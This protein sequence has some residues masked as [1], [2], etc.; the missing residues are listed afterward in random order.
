MA[1]AG[2]HG[3]RTLVLTDTELIAMQPLNP[4]KSTLK[5]L[6]LRSNHISFVPGGYFLGFKQIKKLHFTKNA[7]RLVPDIVTLH[8][9]IV[10]LCFSMHDIHSIHGWLNEAI[11][12]QLTELHLND[13][14]I[15]EFNPNMLSYCPRLKRLNLDRNRLVHLP[16]AYPEDRYKNCSVCAVTFSE[17]P[18]HC[19]RA[20]EGII[21][22]R[23]KESFSARIN[24]NI[25]TPELSRITCSCPLHLRGRDLQTMGMWTTNS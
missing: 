22:L 23:H 7:F 5:Y 14:A 18:I 17:N 2:I 9:T 3:L 15:M 24:C 10:S 4:I 19:D 13:N 6:N 1:F 21:A 20:V 25:E 8:N 12:R 16:L 11:Y